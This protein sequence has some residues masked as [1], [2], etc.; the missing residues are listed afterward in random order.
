MYSVCNR[1]TPPSWL[2]ILFLLTPHNR[3]LAHCPKS[4]GLFAVSTIT[5]VV[6]SHMA[7]CVRCGIVTI[8]G[9]PMSSAFCRLWSKRFNSVLSLPRRCRIVRSRFMVEIVAS[10][11]WYVSNISILTT[12]VC[13][14]PWTATLDFKLP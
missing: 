10:T 6:F 2:V 7:I 9:T 12:Y 1:L 11:R 3:S 4:R 13:V 8:Y 14:T 5:F